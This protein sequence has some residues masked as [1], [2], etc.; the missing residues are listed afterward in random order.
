MI[1]WKTCRFFGNL[2]CI[3][4]IFYVHRNEKTQPQGSYDDDT[5]DGKKEP[6]HKRKNGIFLRGKKVEER[7]G[8]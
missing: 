1:K 6:Y 3:F 5:K 8:Q 7:I 2:L 4:P